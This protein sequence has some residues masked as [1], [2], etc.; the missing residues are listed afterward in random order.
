MIYKA[1]ES[2]KVISC[3]NTELTDTWLAIFDLVGLR[4][5]PDGPA[6]LIL[7]NT[8]N[9]AY[10]NLHLNEITLAYEMAIEGLL[11]N[12]E[13]KPLDPT[14]YGTFSSMYICSI[15]NGYLE[16]KRKEQVSINKALEKKEM[17]KKALPAGENDDPKQAY[18]YLK[19][20]YF[21]PNHHIMKMFGV[22]KGNWGKAFE[23]AERE[24]LVTKTPSEKLEYFNQLKQDMEIEREQLRSSRQDIHE[25]DLAIDNPVQ[26]ARKRL[27]LEYFEK[28]K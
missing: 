23:Y 27:L 25:I 10:F 12:K 24:G 26:E 8:L 18:D 21:D 28:L 3:T 15:L 16:W 7:N 19:T 4:N 5:I 17:E 9:R 13:N 20:Q 11:T 22:P 14:H 2:K 6:Q 1:K